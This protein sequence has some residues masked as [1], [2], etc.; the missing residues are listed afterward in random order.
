MTLLNCGVREDAQPVH[1][2]RNKSW[3][4][5]GR[6]DAEADATILWPPDARSWLTG[7]DP[8]A[9]KDWR[10]G[11]NRRWDGWMVL[12]TW[13]TWIWVSSGSWWCMGKPGV[14]QSMGLQRFG[15]DQAT[16]LAEIW[17]FYHDW[18]LLFLF[19]HY[20]LLYFPVFCFYI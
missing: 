1:S 19:S 9:G 20:S 5:I 15:H 8:D 18:N 3:I 13:W 16:E 10:E 11:D 17:W 4:F 7:K 14:L 6:T 12:P 2:K